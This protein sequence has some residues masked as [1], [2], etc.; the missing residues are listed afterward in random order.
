MQTV[1]AQVTAAH[2]GKGTSSID[3][4]ANFLQRFVWHKL[5]VITLIH[6]TNKREKNDHL[7]KGSVQCNRVKKAIQE[8]VQMGGIHSL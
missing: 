5:R 7:L 8:Y 1:F 4:N 3:N 2:R 6:K